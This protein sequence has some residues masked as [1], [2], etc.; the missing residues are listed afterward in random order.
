MLFSGGCFALRV[1]ISV[2]E[3]WIICDV[4]MTCLV[5]VLISKYTE[6][7]VARDTTMCAITCQSSAGVVWWQILLMM[8][9]MT[10]SPLSTQNP[11][12]VPPYLL[13]P[14]CDNIPLG[15]WWPQ[16]LTRGG[17]LQAAETL[18]NWLIWSILGSN[19]LPHTTD[20]LLLHSAES[21]ICWSYRD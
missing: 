12:A 8:R 5:L 21:S 15:P 11:V 19:V 7:P 10:S 6:S 18:G 14:Y 13:C 9:V 4:N 17:Y 3:N 16:Q 2:A 20:A 1:P